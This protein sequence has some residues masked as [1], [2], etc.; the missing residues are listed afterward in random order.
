MYNVGGALAYTLCLVSS[1]QYQ[2]STDPSLTQRE[3]N[4]SWCFPETLQLVER[5]PTLH[6]VHSPSRTHVNP[7]L[8]ILTIQ[9]CVVCF[10]GYMLS[11]F[12]CH[13]KCWRQPNISH[14]KERNTY[15]ESVKDQYFLGIHCVCTLRILYY[16]QWLI[17]ECRPPLSCMFGCALH[18]I[19]LF[20]LIVSEKGL[21][22][23][24][25]FPV[26]EFSI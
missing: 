13:A 4:P 10:P 14:A 9:C 11:D 8:A 5:K 18:H 3:Q 22:V 21:F 1:E 24:M 12:G 7:F 6:W 15:L 25:P 26:Q 16:I 19:R 2:Y 17:E 20:Y 23:Q